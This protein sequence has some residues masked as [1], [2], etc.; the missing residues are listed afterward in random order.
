MFLK[1]SENEDEGEEKE[2]K[3]T[4]NDR[5]KMI[6]EWKKTFCHTQLSRCGALVGSEESIMEA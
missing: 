2:K 4:T 6:E 1:V 3:Q 5:K